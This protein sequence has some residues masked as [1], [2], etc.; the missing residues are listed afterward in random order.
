MPR[1]PRVR[2]RYTQKQRATF[3]QKSG[4]FWLNPRHAVGGS[5]PRPDLQYRE[6][7]AWW[8]KQLHVRTPR[9]VL[10]AQRALALHTTKGTYGELL[11]YCQE[12]WRNAHVLEWWYADIDRR[13]QRWKRFI[14]EQQSFAALCDRIRAMAP[15]PLEPL[16]GSG[17]DSKVVIAYGAWGARSSGL[18]FRGLPPCIGKGL[19][20]KLSREFIV[21]VVPEHFTSKRCFHCGGEC[22]NHRAISDKDGRTKQKQRLK[23]RLTKR[24]AATTS[25]TEVARARQ[26][27]DRAIARPFEIRGLRLCSR[28]G[29]CL[30][31]DANAARQIAVQLKRLLV[32]AGTLHRRAPMVD[33]G[34]ADEDADDAD[35]DAVLQELRTTMAEDA[36]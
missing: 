19:L 24:L 30:N 7:Q 9:P 36:A 16:R 12:R 14:A 22:G 13:I 29:R 3:V 20:R 34:D 1:K 15:E 27:H 4:N 32:G 18:P 25:P 17:V 11:A 2:V 31:R 8:H 33:A 28:C 10:E 35:V 26:A 5:H 23:A 6:L 21:V